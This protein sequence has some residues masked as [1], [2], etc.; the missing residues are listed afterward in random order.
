MNYYNNIIVVNFIIN[1]I[2]I[3]LC[4]CAKGTKQK[5]NY[6]ISNHFRIMNTDMLKCTIKISYTNDIQEREVIAIFISHKIDIT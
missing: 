5:L 6:M 1:S 2:Y 3:N 4:R